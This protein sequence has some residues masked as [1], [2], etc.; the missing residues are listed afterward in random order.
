MNDYDNDFIS[1]EDM[2]EEERLIVELMSKKS[3]TYY[4]ITN[5][6]G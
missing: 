6:E 4:L 2:S 3:D 5:S 1:W